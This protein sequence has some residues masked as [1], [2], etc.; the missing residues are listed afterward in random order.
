MRNEYNLIVGTKVKVLD[1]SNLSAGDKI[2][3]ILDRDKL[4]VL[5]G[6]F[7]ETNYSNE[8]KERYRDKYL[9]IKSTWW[10]EGDLLRKP[11]TKNKFK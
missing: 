2:G 9:Q 3:T 10:I 7:E 11:R 8:S 1:D 6:F 4:G 5:V